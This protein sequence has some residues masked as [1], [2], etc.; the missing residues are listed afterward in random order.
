[1]QQQPCRNSRR[2]PYCI[3]SV[4][5]YIGSSSV[6]TA[7]SWISLQCRSFFIIWASARK[8]FGSIVPD[9]SATRHMKPNVLYTMH[10]HSVAALRH[11]FCML[12]AH[13]SVTSHCVHCPHHSLRATRLMSRHINFSVLG[14]KLR[15][16]KWI[17]IALYNAAS[18]LW[19]TQIWPVCDKD[20]HSFTCHPH[21]NHTCLYSHEPYLPLLPS[22]K[23]SPPFGRHQFILL[24]EQRHTG[25]RNLPRVFMPR[26]RP[27]VEPTKDYIWPAKLDLL[28]ASPTLYQQCHDA[29][30]ASHFL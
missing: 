26:A 30:S 17:Y 9:I 11:V 1:M 5:M 25:V 27:R 16:R 29:T 3:S 13:T 6:H 15:K 22:H 8:S 23:A 20:T 2:L 4:T 14:V 19:S 12:C 7:Y 28:I 24:G 21:T 10:F 18:D